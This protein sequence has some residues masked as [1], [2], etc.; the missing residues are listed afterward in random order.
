VRGVAGSKVGI[1]YV[2]HESPPEMFAILAQAKFRPVTRRPTTLG[3]IR[4]VFT[5]VDSDPVCT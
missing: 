2:K 1:T 3:K 4:Q 5:Y